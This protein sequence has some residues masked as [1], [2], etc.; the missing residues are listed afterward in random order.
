MQC[1][2]PISVAVIPLPVAVSM[3]APVSRC[4]PVMGIVPAWRFI[5]TPINYFGQ[6]FISEIKNLKN[7]E[8]K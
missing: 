5:T 3:F 1:A 7:K 6:Y 4:V 2:V 8:R